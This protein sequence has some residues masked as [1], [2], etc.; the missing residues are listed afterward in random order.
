MKKIIFTFAAM[1]VLVSCQKENGPKLKDVTYTYSFD[2]SQEEVIGTRTVIDGNVSKWSGKE[3]VRVIGADNSNYY[4]ETEIQGDPVANATFTYTGEQE[5]KGFGDE[6]KTFFA[7]YPYGSSNLTVD[8]EAQTISGINVPTTQ[9]AVEGSYDVMAPVAVAYSTDGKT[10]AFKNV[11]ALVKFQVLIEGVTSVTF[12]GNNGEI[13]SGEGSV[14][15]N[16][17]APKFTPAE[18]KGNTYVE[19]TCDGGFKTRV[20]YYFAILPNTFEKGFKVELNKQRERYLATKMTVSRNTILKDITLGTS[21]PS[22]L[23]DENHWAKSLGAMTLTDDGYY[24]KK[25]V[26]LTASGLKVVKDGFTW[27]S[28]ISPNIQTGCWY[29]IYKTPDSNSKPAIE[30]GTTY[31]IY[32]DKDCKSI[33]VVVNGEQMPEKTLANTQ[34]YIVFRRYENSKRVTNL[35]YWPDGGAYT[36]WP[37]VAS[38]GTVSLSSFGSNYY[39]K[40]PKDL[41]NK[42]MGI[43]FT[44]PNGNGGASYQSSDFYIDSF[45]VDKYYYLEDGDWNYP[46]EVPL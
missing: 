8:D 11:T 27:L 9:T 29:N 5:F 45:I 33:C 15:Y 43:I 37:G 39:W 32:V 1:A 10:L 42:K 38:D 41:Y 6:G 36:S 13:V 28:T 25:N 22:L 30:E 14:S 44:I 23:C 34:L 2:A 26:S 12:S 3:A 19:L 46:I 18:G 35:H 16:D 7:V 17:G 40:I 24:V 31:D 21:V 20:D 4:F